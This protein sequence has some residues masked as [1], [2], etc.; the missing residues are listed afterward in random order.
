MFVSF[1]LFV[2]PALLKMMGRTQLSRPEILATL[3]GEVAGPKGK[4]QY[5]R[6]DVKRTQEGWTATP[7]GARGSNLI[8]T[9][10][11]ANGLAIVPPGPRP[12]R[13]ARRSA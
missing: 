7:T 2:R 12:R 10:A 9:V 3:T 1:E 5:A 8:S 6:V 13:P 4:M 11:R